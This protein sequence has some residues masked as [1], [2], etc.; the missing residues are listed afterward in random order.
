MIFRQVIENVSCWKCEWFRRNDYDESG[1]DPNTG[2]CV[3]KAPGGD[4]AVP[5]GTTGAV[6]DQVGAA[7]AL[8]NATTCSSFKQWEGPAREIITVVE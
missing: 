7:I 6:Q 1:R 4:G 8:P 5:G 2:S 3:A